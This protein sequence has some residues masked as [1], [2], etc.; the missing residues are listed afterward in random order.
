MLSFRNA[1]L[2][3]RHVRTVRRILRL[4][5]VSLRVYMRLKELDK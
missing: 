4:K 1:R 5:D 2:S 3:R